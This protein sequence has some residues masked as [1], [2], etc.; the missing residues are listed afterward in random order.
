MLQELEPW[1]LQ[2]VVTEHRPRHNL[3]GCLSVCSTPAW[4]S[5][6][7]SIVC[8]T[9]VLPG[10]L[11][12]TT[13]FLCCLTAVG[14]LLNSVHPYVPV[15]KWSAWAQTIGGLPI[16]SWTHASTTLGPKSPP[17]P[18]RPS[19]PPPKH[20]NNLAAR[21]DHCQISVYFAKQVRHWVNGASKNDQTELGLLALAVKWLEMP[22][23][24]S[25]HSFPSIRNLHFN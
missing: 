17:S 7:T 19:P 5:C 8:L 9:K 15:T 11:D 21:W 20:T 18:P 22:S 1:R 3:Q 14:V 6:N 2:S 16:A 12:A 4:T 10:F 23:S 25:L 24:D 13:Q